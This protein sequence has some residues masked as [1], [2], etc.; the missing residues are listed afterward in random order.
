LK[1]FAAA[2]P[3]RGLNAPAAAAALRNLFAGLSLPIVFLTIGP[4]PG[5]CDPSSPDSWGIELVRSTGAGRS[6]VVGCATG[7]GATGDATSSGAGGCGNGAVGT[8]G[9]GAVGG[10]VGCD[11]GGSVSAGGAMFS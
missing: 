10:G 8:C 11:G 5:R 4:R 1:S 6:G 7:T 3:A 2:P 9:S